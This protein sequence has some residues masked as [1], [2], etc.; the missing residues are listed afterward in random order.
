MEGIASDWTL[1]TSGVHQGS[2]LGPML[3][4]LFINDLPNVVPQRTEAL[5][6]MLTTPKLSEE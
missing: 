3:F 2:I 5:P 4:V 6:Y 1:V